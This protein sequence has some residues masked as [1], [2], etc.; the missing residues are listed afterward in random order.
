MSLNRKRVEKVIA[1]RLEPLFRLDGG[2]VSVSA[3]DEQR[4][5]VSVRF[6]GTYRACPG[7]DLLIEK[8]L[9]P[10]LRQELPGLRGVSEG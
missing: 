9:E 1:E 4:G 3:V 2:E 7:R 10:T 5:L 8:V 6:G